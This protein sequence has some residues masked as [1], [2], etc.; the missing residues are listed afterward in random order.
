V[1]LGFGDAGKGLCVDWLCSEDSGGALVARFSGGHQVGHTVRRDGLRHVFSNFCSGALAGSPGYFSD[2]TTVFPPGLAREAA[3]LDALPGAPPRTLWLDPLAAVA[4]PADIAWNR[5]RERALGHGSCGVGYGAAVVRTRAGVSLRVKDL[6]HPWV[7]REKLA[8]VASYYES[9]LGSG[10]AWADSFRE[11]L[12]GLDDEA[13]VDACRDARRRYGKASW[14]ELSGRYGR[15]VLEGNQGILLDEE[16]GIFPYVT[17]GRCGSAP[18][19]ELLERAARPVVGL[20]I[21]YVT[22]CYQTRHGSGPMSSDKPVA[23]VGADGETNAENEWQG[24]FRVAELDPDLLLYALETDAARGERSLA[25][26]SS[27]GCPIRRNLLVTCLDQRPGFDPDALVARLQDG[28]ARL[29][30]A[31]GGSSPEAAGVFE[32]SP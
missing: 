11:E 7:L 26:L 19:L 10:P 31:Y 4:A 27:A 17:W 16:D 21:Y 12:E 5:A 1:D 2:G 32:L 24:A 29:D 30:R 22:R 20:D 6:D 23:L 8:G 9:L 25:R 14:T 13:F 15:V 18:A 3:A 28:G